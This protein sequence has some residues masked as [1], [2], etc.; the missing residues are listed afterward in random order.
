LNDIL[1]FTEIN[2]IQEVEFLSNI[3]DTEIA[4]DKQSIVDVLC[5]DS[6]GAKYVIEMQLALDKGFE[7]PAQLYAVTAYST[8]ADKYGR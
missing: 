1:G 3:M 4:S 5:R 6:G 8:Q 2:T 7:K